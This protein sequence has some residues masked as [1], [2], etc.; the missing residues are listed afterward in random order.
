VNFKHLLSWVTILTAKDAL[1]DETQGALFLASLLP[2]FPNMN[3]LIEE[4]LNIH[5]AKLPTVR[6]VGPILVIGSR[7]GKVHVFVERTLV[8]ENHVVNGV[9][10]HVDVDQTEG[11]VVVRSLAAK[12][13]VV[14]SLSGKK[15]RFGKKGKEVRILEERQLGPETRKLGRESL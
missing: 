7:D 15:R 3:N 1:R 2:K 6:K 11:K 12:K 4:E 8:Y 9:I 10:D 14:L 13:L 5:Q